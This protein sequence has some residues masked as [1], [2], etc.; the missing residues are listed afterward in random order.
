MSD[1][2]LFQVK[3]SLGCRVWQLPAGASPSRELRNQT[4]QRVL[5]DGRIMDVFEYWRPNGQLPEW[6]DVYRTATYTLYVLA[7][8]TE[9][10]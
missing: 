2:V 9:R 1:P 7:C 6:Y 4:P 3:A 10:V 8:E 5:T